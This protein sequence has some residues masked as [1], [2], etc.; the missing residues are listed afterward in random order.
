MFN[1]IKNQNIL[2]LLT[3]TTLPG[4]AL[5]KTKIFTTPRTVAWLSYIADI[6]GKVYFL[7]LFLQSEHPLIVPI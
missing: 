4:R 2:P 1:T 6:F 7:T 5:G 3:I